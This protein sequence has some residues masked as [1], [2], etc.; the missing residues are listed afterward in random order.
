[1]HDYWNVWA[2][3][4]FDIMMAKRDGEFD[5]L[6]KNP[7]TTF[8]EYVPDKEYYG[9]K[10]DLKIIPEQF[11][12]QTNRL[13]RIYN[14][15]IAQNEIDLSKLERIVNLAQKAIYKGKGSE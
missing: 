14:N 13:V 7:L 3:P 4:A 6:R 11:I 8:Q 15:L 12:H 10:C 9:Q 1:M 2:S 5:K